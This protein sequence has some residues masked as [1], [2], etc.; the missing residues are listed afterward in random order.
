ME[1][2]PMVN[3]RLLELR[4]EKIRSS[5]FA[6]GKVY[7]PVL[8]KRLSLFFK[9]KT[10]AQNYGF[11]VQVRWIRLYDAAVAG[12]ATQPAPLSPAVTSPQMD[13]SALPQNNLGG[14]VPTQ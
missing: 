10:D 5:K 8:T 13:P 2:R 11:M 6:G 9:R 3:P 7:A 4:I 12:L 1:K 14:E